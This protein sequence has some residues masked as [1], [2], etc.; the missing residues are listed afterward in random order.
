MDSKSSFTTRTAF[1]AVAENGR[2]AI[3]DFRR[4][5]IMAGMGIKLSEA[6][7]STL[8]AI[9]ALGALATVGATVD[10]GATGSDA[11]AVRY[12]QGPSCGSYVS[13]AVPQTVRFL[14]ENEQLMC[15]TSSA[16]VL[17]LKQPLA[18]GIKQM[19][20]LY[21]VDDDSSGYAN[22]Y[23]TANQ[24][25]VEDRW[26]RVVAIRIG[27]VVDSGEYSLPIDKLSSTASTLSLLGLD[28]VVA[29][30]DRKVYKVFN[31][32]IQLRNLNAIIQ[33]Q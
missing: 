7:N 6:G 19:K 24:L 3:Q 30:N 11:V 12:R 31:T 20:A 18:S 27:M 33:Q 32:T 10:G 2:F 28:Y 9:P 1:S 21:G 29:A 8:R 13:S 4:S 16:G 17:I 5:L 23:L 26:T 15:E 22:R 25:N 14:V